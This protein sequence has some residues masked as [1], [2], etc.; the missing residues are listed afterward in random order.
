M[1]C[2]ARSTLQTT[3]SVQSAQS[4]PLR[5]GL[6]GLYLLSPGVAG[7]ALGF[8]RC[9]TTLLPSASSTGVDSGIGR[10]GMTSGADAGLCMVVFHKMRAA[11]L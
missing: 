2:H 4:L 9:W 11:P 8:G 10:G 6:R 5:Y 7:S 3:V 1:E